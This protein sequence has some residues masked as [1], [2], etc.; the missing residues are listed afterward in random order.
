MAIH[1]SKQIVYSECGSVLSGH[2]LTD[3]YIY[4]CMFVMRWMLCVLW[5]I[6]TYSDMEIDNLFYRKLKC[7]LF[8]GTFLHFIFA[9][10]ISIW[11]IWTD[12]KRKLVEKNTLHITLVLFVFTCFFCCCS[13][14]SSFYA[15]HSKSDQRRKS[16]IT[17]N[18]QCQCP[19]VFYTSKSEGANSFTYRH[20][21]N[22]LWRTEKKKNKNYEQKS[23]KTSKPSHNAFK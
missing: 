9:W 15:K 23:N 13:C 21:Q 11:T 12:N 5:M 17:N 3:D 22:I 7:L 1:Y 18:N 8:G 16:V 10:F 2:T 14:N 19:C 6:I 4:D 20:E